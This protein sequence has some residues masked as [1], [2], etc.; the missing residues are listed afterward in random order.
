MRITFAHYRNRFCMYRTY[1]ALIK[2]I[3]KPDGFTMNVIKLPHAP[4]QKQ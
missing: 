4:R 2:V 3:V 1:C